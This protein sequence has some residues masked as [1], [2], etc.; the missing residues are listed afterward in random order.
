MSE[1]H[2]NK[3]DLDVVQV[4][5]YVVKDDLNEL[6]STIYTNKIHLLFGSLSLKN[7]IVKCA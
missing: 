5:N 3:K 2:Q 7:I 6:I 1:S 4:W